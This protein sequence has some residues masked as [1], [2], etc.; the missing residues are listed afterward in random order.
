MQGWVCDTAFQEPHG[1]PWPRKR[2]LPELLVATVG[3]L[4]GLV[5]C[6]AALASLSLAGAHD[7]GGLRPGTLRQEAC[8]GRHRD[9]FLPRDV[10]ILAFSVAI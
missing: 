6:T 1:T 4:E 5:L 8:F 10:Q 9:T 2:V 3:A 7:I